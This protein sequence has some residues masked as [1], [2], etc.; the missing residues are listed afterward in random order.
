MKLNFPLKLFMRCT[1]DMTSME[2]G[3]KGGG[4]KFVSRKRS[5][6]WFHENIPS[7]FHLRRRPFG[8]APLD[9]QKKY[10][11]CPKNLCREL[12]ETI[13]SKAQKNGG[14]GKQIKGQ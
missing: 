11:I 13:P 8:T 6:L 1:Q 5:S 12:V 3:E 4:G 9:A 2:S 10:G 14:L 7:Q